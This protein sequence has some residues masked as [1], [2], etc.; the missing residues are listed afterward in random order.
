M[1]SDGEVDEGMRRLDEATAAAMGGEVD[2]PDAV[3]SAC[4]YLIDA[5]K[6]TRDYGRAAQWCERVA[7]FSERWSDRITFAVCRTH[8]ADILIWRGPWDQAERELQTNLGPLAEI[9]S[10]RV[11]DALV[12]LAELRRRQGRAPEAE[13]LATAAEGHPLVPLVRG[14]LALDRGDPVAATQ[15][16]ERALRRMPRTGR[17]DR[18]AALELLVRATVAAGDAPRGRATPRGAPT[19]MPSTSSRG[20]VG[21]SRRP[22]PGATW[23]GRCAS[24]AGTR[25][26]PARPGRPT[27]RCAAWAPAPAPRP[28]RAPP[29]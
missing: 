19:R 15:E 17:T 21:A 25:P 10:G 23:P 5:C 20:P 6:R 7:E 24:S 12:R 18:A 16:A 14:G 9:N 1:V 26:P 28:T 8:Y 4:C 3:S 27:T 22:R 11:A 29:G 13:R 2:D